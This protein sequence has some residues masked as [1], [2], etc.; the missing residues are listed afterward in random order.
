M[1]NENEITEFKNN[2]IAPYG[3]RAINPSFDVTNNNLI[4]G[5]I[6]EKGFIDPAIPGEL[7]RV[8][9]L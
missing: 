8:L 3:S 2:L 1:R 9:K 7:E 6:C 5:I 4:T